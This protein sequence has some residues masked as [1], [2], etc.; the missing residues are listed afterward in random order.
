MHYLPWGYR[1][2]TQ[3]LILP[4][5]KRTRTSLPLT[6]FVAPKKLEEIDKVPTAES[7]TPSLTPTHQYDSAKGT[8]NTVDNEEVEHVITAA[9]VV[10][11]PDLPMEGDVTELVPN[12]LFDPIAILEAVQLLHADYVDHQNRLDEFIKEANARI[13]KLEEIISSNDDEDFQKCEES[14]MKLKNLMS[15]TNRAMPK[16]YVSALSFCDY[17]NQQSKTRSNL[18]RF[19]QLDSEDDSAPATI[20]PSVLQPSRTHDQIQSSVTSPNP[21]SQAQSSSQPR[22]SDHEVVT[23]QQEVE[24]T[25]VP[26]RNHLDYIPAH[27]P[28]EMLSSDVEDLGPDS[29][30]ASPHMSPHRTMSSPTTA[31]LCLDSIANVDRIGSSPPASHTPSTHLEGPSRSTQVAQPNPSLTPTL[32]S[33]STNTTTQPRAAKRPR[34]TATLPNRPKSSLPRPPSKKQKGQAGSKKPYVKRQMVNPQGSLPVGTLLKSNGVARVKKATWP[35]SGP[36]T[37]IGLGGYIECEVVSS[38]DGRETRLIIVFWAC[39]PFLC[40]TDGS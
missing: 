2:P 1:R 31:A 39:T 37:V 30:I 20:D 6:R 13:K 14:L 24:T 9:D 18:S 28:S 19:T 40:G 32:P 23:D 27:D 4:S 36:N 10:D 21:S 25:K 26:G 35:K 34:R 8:N 11:T 16:V 33:S 12:Q 7:S 3:P 22:V 38:G 5:M 29:P 15:G 17:D